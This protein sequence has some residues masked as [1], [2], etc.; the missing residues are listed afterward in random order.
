MIL[1]LG[2][3]HDIYIHFIYRSFMKIQ[4]QFAARYRMKLCNQFSLVP[5]RE[6]GRGLINICIYLSAIKK[7]VNIILSPFW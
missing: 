3:T 1:L 2:Y 6:G 7:L 5:G 4:I